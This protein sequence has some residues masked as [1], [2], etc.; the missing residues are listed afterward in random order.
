MML[1]PSMSM[2]RA[3]AAAGLMLLM[4]SAGR[5][6][7]QSCT[8]PAAVD[9]VRQVLALRVTIP[10]D[11]S[12]VP[13]DLAASYAA[14]IAAAFVAP[15]PLPLRMYLHSRSDSLETPP[16]LGALGVYA[17]YGIVPSSSAAPA[18]AIAYAS[19]LS[20][21]L[22]DAVMN[23]IASA[24]DTSASGTER[25]RSIG[26]LRIYVSTVDSLRPHDVGLQMIATPRYRFDRLASP[27]GRRPPMMPRYPDAMRTAGLEGSVEMTFVIDEAGRPVPATLYLARATN[28]AFAQA[29]T[30]SITEHRFQPAT[31]GGCAVATH[32]RMPFKFSVNNT[33]T[34]RRPRPRAVPSPSSPQ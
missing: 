24:I 31:I 34:P 4:M 28:R 20:Q 25:L 3:A 15:S 32:V 10:G 23:A 29:V 5:A 33:P 6:E 7:A 21:A 9:T 13:N 30:N 11:T 18:T 27:K 1:I 16:R 12:G 17:V 19:S 2:R 26:G 8:I 14:Q 22:D